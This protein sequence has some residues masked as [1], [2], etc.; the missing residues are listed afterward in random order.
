MICAACTNEMLHHFGNKSLDSSRPTYLNPLFSM[1][2]CYYHPRRRR[3][4][5]FFLVVLWLN[6]FVGLFACGFVCL[7]VCGSVQKSRN[8]RIFTKFHSHIALDDPNKFIESQGPRSV[9][10]FIHCFLPYIS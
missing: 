9:R 10:S 5:I 1:F 7:F 8:Y 6:K 2:N 4:M 3:G